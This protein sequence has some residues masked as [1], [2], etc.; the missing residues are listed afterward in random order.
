[1]SAVPSVT[2]EAISQLSAMELRRSVWRRWG[3]R[4]IV[5]VGW[6][7]F[8]GIWY[9]FSRI[10]GSALL[11]PP[12]TIIARSWELITE[13][14]FGSNLTSSLTRLLGGFLLAL[15]AG[16]GVGLLI[17]Y[18]DWWQNLLQVP[19]QFVTSLPTISLAVMTLILFGISPVGPVLVTMLVALPYIARNVAQGITGVDRRLIVM[20][21]AFGRTR[22]QIV[23]DIL[24]PSSILSTLGG[25]R[26]AFAAAWRMELL[27]EVFGS[28]QGIGFH[29][30]RSFE[31]Y[32]TQSMLAWTV[33]FVAVMLVFENLILRRIDRWAGR[34]R[35][36]EWGAV[37]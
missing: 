14:G 31:S 18:N 29:I 12:H 1:M 3:S 7:V 4:S 2:P 32:D 22:A 23:K 9:L 25:A 5:V 17:A 37:Q 15:A 34:W 24:I 10:L 26:L 6:A 27:A 20:S 35:M 11:P 8:V 30:R 28:S 21:E 16:A 33:L 13:E 36:Q 19:L